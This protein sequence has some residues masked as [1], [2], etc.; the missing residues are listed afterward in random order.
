MAITEYA[1]EAQVGEMVFPRRCNIRRLKTDALF[2]R[3][4][5][6]RVFLISS[7]LAIP[8]F[9]LLATQPIETESNR[10][11]N[12]TSLTDFIGGSVVVNLFWPAN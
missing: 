10:G 5:I 1:G 4:I 7:G 8:Y 6:V 2:R 12:G 11:E 3:F 9:I